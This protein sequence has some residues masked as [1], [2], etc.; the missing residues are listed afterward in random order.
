MDDIFFRQFYRSPSS[1]AILHLPEFETTQWRVVKTNNGG[2]SRISIIYSESDI[3]Q[4]NVN[5]IF[6]PRF[7][8]AMTAKETADIF[9]ERIQKEDPSLR[10]VGAGENIDIAGGKAFSYQLAGKASKGT[11]RITYIIGIADGRCAMGIYADSTI[12]RIDEMSGV[13][14]M[15]L[16]TIALGE[17]IPVLKNSGSGMKLKGVYEGP[18]EILWDG[19]YEQQWFI[20]DPRGYC[21]RSEPMSI[22]ELDVEARYQ[23]NKEKVMKYRVR[24]KKMIITYPDGERFIYNFHKIDDRKVS[25]DGDL[26]IRIDGVLDNDSSLSGHYRYAA[27]KANIEGNTNDIDSRYPDFCFSPEKEFRLLGDEQTAASG[28]YRILDNLLYLS[29]IDGRKEMHT[30]F[31]HLEN[32]HTVSCTGF[33][34][35]GRYY[36]KENP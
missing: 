31:P 9:V 15:I 22:L 35:D 12:D 33:Y 11:L 5:L 29:F 13:A 6:L 16:E 20:F 10:K 7:E 34:I 1:T 21:H 30:I 32:E 17:K 4:G 28:T 27:T 25:I 18:H 3:D 19:T 23:W 36:E 2:E 8:R 14:F 24:G 26:F